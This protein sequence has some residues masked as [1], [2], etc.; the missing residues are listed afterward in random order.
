MYH[1]VGDSY[2]STKQFERHLIFYQKHFE[3]FWAS[4]ADSILQ[5]QYQT[6]TG[7]PPLI[8]TFDDGLENNFL[9]VAPL[10]EKM[11]IKSTFYLVSNLLDGSNMLWNH[12][13]S[14]RLELMNNSELNKVD[15]YFLEEMN[16]TNK[17]NVIHNFVAN[18]KKWQHEKQQSLLNKLRLQ[19]PAPNYT[20]EMKNDFFIMS[21]AQ[22][23]LLPAIIEVGSHTCTHPILDTIGIENAE[24]EI[25]QSKIQLETM[26]NKPVR[27]FCYPNGNLTPEV[28]KIVQNNYDMA[29]TV[30]KGF[31]KTNDCLFQLRR[32]PAT[33]QLKDLS[34]RLLRP[35]S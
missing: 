12:E 8:L 26:L 16:S 14:C 27:S 3:M 34:Y 28:I 32:I 9:K 6:A 21:K 1:G 7:K 4:E 33:P 15:K 35:S 24:K 11:K 5:S 2:L 10:L 13:M 25:Y 29:I 19:C 18:M 17:K 20:K 22:A 23:T 30:K 31:V